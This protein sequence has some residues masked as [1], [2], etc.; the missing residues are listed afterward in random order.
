M[1]ASRHGAQLLP[2]KV[3]PLDASVAQ[4]DILVPA[5]PGCNPQ[6][7]PG[8]PL[9]TF[10]LTPSFRS[11]PLG[12]AEYEWACEHVDGFAEIVAGAMGLDKGPITAVTT[13]NAGQTALRPL[14]SG[15]TLEKVQAAIP[16]W[17]PRSVVDAL[18]HWAAN[19]RGKPLGE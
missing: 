10:P 8:N 11:A 6:D 14:D 2:P 9:V 12:P 18:A 13:S 1:A 15:L 5:L 4:L 16:G 19:P 17:K 3:D 7:T